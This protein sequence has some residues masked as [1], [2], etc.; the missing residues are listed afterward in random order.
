MGNLHSGGGGGGYSIFY[1]L[2]AIYLE[3]LG[4][5]GGEAKSGAGGAFW[6]TCYMS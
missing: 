3:K 2:T 4:L 6:V 5:R 1:T